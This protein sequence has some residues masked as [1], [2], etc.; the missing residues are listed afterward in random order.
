MFNKKII[1]TAYLLLTGS[2]LSAITVKPATSFQDKGDFQDAK[3]H[4][5]DIQSVRPA[6]KE[7][8]RKLAK[9]KAIQNGGDAKVHEI[10]ATKI[11]K[12]LSKHPKLAQKVT[13]ENPLHSPETLSDKEYFDMI[14]ELIEY[15]GYEEFSYEK[16][17]EEK[18]GA[19]GA[20]KKGI[21]LVNKHNGDNVFIIK[22]V[23]NSGEFKPLQAIYDWDKYVPKLT[24]VDKEAGVNVT[25]GF[26]LHEA[27]IKV[28]EGDDTKYY[29]VLHAAQG[30]PLSFHY[31]N[32]EYM[33]L[34]GIALGMVQKR[35]KIESEDP[36]LDFNK[37]IDDGYFVPKLH[38]DF[39]GGNIF[40]KK[41]TNPDT[42]KTECIITLIDLDFM[43]KSIINP[44]WSNKCGGKSD[45]RCSNWANVMTLKHMYESE[46]QNTGSTKLFAKD[47]PSYIAFLDG[48]LSMFNREN[49]KALCSRMTL[50]HHPASTKPS[51]I[52][53]CEFPIDTNNIKTMK[54][55]EMLLENHEL[56]EYNKRLVAIT[57]ADIPE[58][59]QEEVA[60]LVK[61]LMTKTMDGYHIIYLLK[62]VRN[63]QQKDRQEFVKFCI[64]LYNSEVYED[65][66]IRLVKIVFEKYQ[67]EGSRVW[68]ENH[69]QEAFFAE[70]EQS[71]PAIILYD[72]SGMPAE[73]R[74][75]ISQTVAKLPKSERSEIIGYVKLLLTD[76]MDRNNMATLIKIVHGIPAKNRKKFVEHCLTLYNYETV[77]DEAV[78]L[79]QNQVSDYMY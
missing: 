53:A 74:K 57:L 62:I 17:S 27:L 5:T 23:G 36:S 4:T 13:K 33:H 18:L 3:T 28:E 30:E 19:G 65:E 54:I 45:L 12:Y 58:N 2:C 1:S 26:S 71:S 44:L 25:V 55:A 10:T 50:L 61:Q 59:W 6:I 7:K 49:R 72:N 79:I 22:E 73:G 48:Y 60:T 9:T 38:L 32:N 56:S 76:G 70:N 47:Q 37:T 14:F 8:L 35:Y 69:A 29:E 24:H 42:G 43:G 51:Q 41:K 39:H 46:L 64:T 78:A 63:V 52:S 77:D 40:I 15:T 67:A 11:E 68:T 16:L 21:Y 75:F 34:A 66:I 31:D 20:F